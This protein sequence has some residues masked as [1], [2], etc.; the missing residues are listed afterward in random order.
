[1]PKGKTNQPLI[2]M[3]TPEMMASLTMKA[4]AAQGHTVR[5]LPRECIDVDLIMGVNCH[6]FTDDMLNKPG[7][8]VAAMKAARKRKKE[9]KS[10][11]DED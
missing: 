4:M 8:M 1:M 6:M 5:E 2:M 7:I 3:V 11:K 9:K 10:V